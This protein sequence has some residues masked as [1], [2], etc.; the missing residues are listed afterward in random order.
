MFAI[1]G[2]FVWSIFAL[3]KKNWSEFSIPD[4]FPSCRYWQDGTLD[5]NIISRP[6]ISD[7]LK[8]TIHTWKS[9]L[10]NYARNQIMKTNLKHGWTAYCSQTLSHPSFR[11]ISRLTKTARLM[12][13][14]NLCWRLA[15]FSEHDRQYTYKC[16]T[17]AS[18]RKHCC[19]GKEK[20][21]TYSHCGS[22]ALGIQHAKCRITRILSSAVSLALPCFSIWSH[23]RNDFRKTL[24][25][26]KCV[27][28]FSP[29]L[30]SET[31]LLLLIFILR[32][33]KK[34]YIGLHAKSLLCLSD[35]N[36]TWIFSTDFRKMLKNQFHANPSSGSR[37]VPL[38]GADRRT[39]RS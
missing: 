14:R 11:R 26:I 10:I 36:V 4:K 27:F 16:N 38:G 25:N 33:I 31:F 29:N 1:I 19:R 2:S 12:M 30:L 28:W 39:W 8:E 21:I 20:S 7:T 37:V 17:E 18:S 24:L 32:M 13:L 6:P 23:K 5:R 15:V 35:F 34:K 9:Y 22:V 3:S